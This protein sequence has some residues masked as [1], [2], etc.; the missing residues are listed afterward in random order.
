MFNGTILMA[1]ALE[2]SA[3][4]VPYQ[5]SLSYMIGFAGLL[6]PRKLKVANIKAS[7]NCRNPKFE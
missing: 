6:L 3:D 4:S 5:K 2:P 7:D 1:P